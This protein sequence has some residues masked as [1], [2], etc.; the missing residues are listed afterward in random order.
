MDELKQYVDKLFARAPK[1]ATLRDLKEEIYTNLKAH[2]Q[3]LL[4]QG[5]SAGDAQRAA[6]QGMLSLEGLIWG[7]QRVYY[8]PFVAECCQVLL[9]HALLLWVLLL[10][11]M[12]V[13]TGFLAT[14]VTWGAFLLAMGCAVATLILRTRD[15]KLVRTVQLT[16]L[17]RTA[18]TMWLLWA[19]FFAVCVLAI[20]A[21]LFGSNVWFGRPVV[22]DGPYQFGVLAARYYL[23]AATVL[24]PA[25][26][27][28]FVKL[29]A[30]HEAGEENA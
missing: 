9:L 7:E 27:A 22:I 17:R 25:A 26:V 19:V 15:A 12:L 28:R 11:L 2:E 1:T 24:L 10:P 13:N 4:S 5:M 18:R 8:Y 20:T 6:K 29:V 14:L 3:D 21:V 30:G 16:A 23:P